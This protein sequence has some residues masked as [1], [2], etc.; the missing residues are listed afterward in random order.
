MTNVTNLPVWP[1]VG[2]TRC[3]FYG[4][5]FFDKDGAPVYEIGDPII[6]Y[7]EDMDCVTYY[8]ATSQEHTVKDEAWAV[9][10]VILAE[11][12]EE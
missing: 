5:E 12:Y 8:T 4:L 11:E 7:V 9:R 3:C 2:A 10:C 1:P 6:A